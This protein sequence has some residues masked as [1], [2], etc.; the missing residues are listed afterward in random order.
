[1]RLEFHGLALF[2]CIILFVSI[3]LFGRNHHAKPY[4]I[5]LLSLCGALLLPAFIPGHGEIIMALPNA[6]LFTVFNSMAWGVGLFYLVINFFISYAALNII[7][8]YLN[9][10]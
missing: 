5:F 10:K 2:I 4:F 9:L 7:K 8:K 3:W 1:M 6:A